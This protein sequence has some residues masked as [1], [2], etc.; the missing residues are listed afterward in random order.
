M[1]M[2]SVISILQKSGHPS[3]RACDWDGAQDFQAHVGKDGTAHTLYSILPLGAMSEWQV[4]A[5]TRQRQ[6]RTP[7]EV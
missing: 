1:C 3:P 7:A 2:S 6:D 5:K 4:E